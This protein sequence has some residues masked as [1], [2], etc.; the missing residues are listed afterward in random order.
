MT[1]YMRF[2][3]SGFHKAFVAHLTHELV[4]SGM[5]GS[6]LISAPLCGELFTTV[7]TIP[8]S[9]RLVTFRHGSSP[10]AFVQ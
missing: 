5:H 6:V 9:A 8:G 2:E 3:H 4:I 1:E 10:V 7:F